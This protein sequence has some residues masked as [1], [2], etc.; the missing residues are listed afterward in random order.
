MF[1]IFGFLGV[2]VPRPPAIA[3]ILAK[4]SVPL[5]VVTL[6]DPSSSL[7]KF[8]AVSPRVYEGLKGLICS[9]RFSIKSPAII[10]G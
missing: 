8:I 3:I 9:N 5:S 7:S 10:S 2:N 6:K 4:I 1:D